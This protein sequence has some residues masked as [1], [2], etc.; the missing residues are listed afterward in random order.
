VPLLWLTG[1]I[2]KYDCRQSLH[3]P[4][5]RYH[6]FDRRHPII[7]KSYN[8]CA[9]LYNNLPALRH[10]FAKEKGDSIFSNQACLCGYENKIEAG[11]VYSQK[12]KNNFHVPW[13]Y[14][15]VVSIDAQN[16]RVT[17]KNAMP[18]DGAEETQ[19]TC[20]LNNFP[21]IFDV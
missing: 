7:R 17:F 2:R 16:N 18:A 20:S 4:D 3:F 21:K 9:K 14:I 13:K 19:A 6:P 12:L 5:C 8:T 15:V 11:V 1:I 10:S